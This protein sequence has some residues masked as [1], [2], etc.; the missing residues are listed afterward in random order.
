[1]K[2][3][4]LKRIRKIQEIISGCYSDLEE[5]QEELQESFDNKS[6]NWQESEKGEEAQEEIDSVEEL[7][8]NCDSLQSD[9]ED[10]LNERE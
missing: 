3:A 2:K 6:E 9:I 8:D 4:Q 5:I 1:M 7:K 10:F